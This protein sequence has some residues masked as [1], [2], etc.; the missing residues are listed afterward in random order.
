MQ[1]RLD[2]QVHNLIIILDFSYCKLSDHVFLNLM[3]LYKYK[4]HEVYKM[5]LGI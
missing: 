3:Y 2:S 4:M 5:C 1:I